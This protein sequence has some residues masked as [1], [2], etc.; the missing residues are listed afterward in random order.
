MALL[1]R[2]VGL[3]PTIPEYKYALSASSKMDTNAIGFEHLY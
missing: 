2:M 1:P 3:H